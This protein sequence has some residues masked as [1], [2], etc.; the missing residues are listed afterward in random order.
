M[1]YAPS[2][3]ILAQWSEEDEAL[4]RVTAGSRPHDV[5]LE[6]RLEISVSYAHINE[7]NVGRLIT[8]SKTHCG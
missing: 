6:R 2:A 3:A 1:H 4:L 8:L 5:T 7:Q